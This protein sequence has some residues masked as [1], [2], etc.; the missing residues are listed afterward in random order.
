MDYASKAAQAFKLW[1]LLIPGFDLR[2][3][4]LHVNSSVS[5]F[6]RFLQSLS[7]K[8]E[9]YRPSGQSYPYTFLKIKENAEGFNPTWIDF[10][11]LDLL[12]QFI[13][14]CT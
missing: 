14:L 1:L 11:L 6:E 13:G 10:G 3:C 9:V 2:K 12:I 8:S 7:V 4:R 5:W